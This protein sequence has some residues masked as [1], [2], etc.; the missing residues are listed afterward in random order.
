MTRP[1]LSLLAGVGLLFLAGVSRA[2]IINAHSGSYSDVSTAVASAS[3]G[4][5]VMIPSGTNIWTQTLNISGI[6]LS[7][8]NASDFAISGAP[9]SV[10]AAVGATPGTATFTVTFTPT[11]SN[12][13]NATVHIAND[14][15][16]ESDYDFA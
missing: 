5:T 9:A 14:D 3:L 12:V 15:C 1:T 11:A 6:T 10:P 7:G 16:D 13:R 4:D 8:A 2:N